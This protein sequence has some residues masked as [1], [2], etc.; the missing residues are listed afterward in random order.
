MLPVQVKRITKVKAIGDF[1]DDCYIRYAPSNRHLK[2]Q[3]FSLT[4]VT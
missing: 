1:S 4:T 2:Q 3:T